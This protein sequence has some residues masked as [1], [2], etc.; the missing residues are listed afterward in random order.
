MGGTHQQAPVQECTAESF[1]RMLDADQVETGVIEIHRV[2]Q[3]NSSL[4]A[5]AQQVEKTFETR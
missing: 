2:D 3:E 1:V 5:G 4:T